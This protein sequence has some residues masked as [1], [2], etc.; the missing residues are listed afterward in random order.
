MS[1]SIKGI[2]RRVEITQQAL[3]KSAADICRDTG[4]KPNQWSQYLNAAAKRPI[5]RQ[6]IFKLKD[7]YGITF[8]WL[9]DGD[10]AS[11][12]DRAPDRLRSKVLAIV[13][14]QIAA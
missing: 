11:L 5:T 14:N 1:R 7:A 13:K 10:I 12:P 3:E 8:E 6:A 9:Y 4:I 2:A